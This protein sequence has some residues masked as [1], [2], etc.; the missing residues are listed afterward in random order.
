MHCSWIQN[1][2]VYRILSEGNLYIRLEID[3][4]WPVSTVVICW[5]PRAGKHNLMFEMLV[6][7]ELWGSLCSMRFSKVPK[8][9]DSLKYRP[10]YSGPVMSFYL[11]Q[12]SAVLGQHLRQLSRLAWKHKN[13]LFN[14]HT[15]DS[16]ANNFVIGVYCRWLQ[17][18]YQIAF[19]YKI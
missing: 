8:I 7:N 15:R 18:L 13:A 6:L 9:P 11:D 16:I 12:C 10:W 19:F 1:T 17:I 14:D 4:M 2:F 5:Q 3:I